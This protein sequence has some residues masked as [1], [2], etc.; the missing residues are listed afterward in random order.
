MS[1][2]RQKK[3]KFQFFTLTLFNYKGLINA[4]INQYFLVP[5][6]M[7]LGTCLIFNYSLMK[8][9]KVYEIQP[10]T[11]AERTLFLVSLTTTRGQKFLADSE[12]LHGVTKEFP[13]ISENIILPGGDY[14]LLS[15][16][17]GHACSLQDAEDL[18]KVVRVYGSVYVDYVSKGQ[19]DFYFRLL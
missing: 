8:P 19:Y 18:V 14:W 10:M 7:D 17:D 15:V 3:D 12:I 11:E 2:L 9:L 4:C 5:L 16:G 6:Y 1:F 13:L